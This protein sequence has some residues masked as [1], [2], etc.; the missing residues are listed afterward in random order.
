MGLEP[1]RRL[2]HIEIGIGIGAQAA[3]HG[4]SGARIGLQQWPVPSRQQIARSRG[5]L[6]QQQGAQCDPVKR[7]HAQTGVRELQ[8]QRRLAVGRRDM[9]GGFH[10]GAQ[11]RQH[12][13]ASPRQTLRHPVAERWQRG[14]P[15]GH[16]AKAGQHDRH[17]AAPHI[18]QAPGQCGRHQGVERVGQPPGA[19]GVEHVRG[20]RGMGQH[21]A[22]GLATVQKACLAQAAGGP[23]VGFVV[24]GQ[25][26]VEQGGLF[27]HG[28]GR[29]MACVFDIRSG[30]QCADGVGV[31]QREVGQRS[32]CRWRL[33]PRQ[34]QQPA[35]KH[36]VPA[37]VGMQQ[38]FQRKVLPGA[39]CGMGAHK[40]KVAHAAA[41]QQ[42]CDFGHVGSAVAGEL[43]QDFRVA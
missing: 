11:T 41:A 21:D 28:G 22:E 15:A 30:R 40:G 20:I 32:Q 27:V 5:G 37:P 35:C 9:G 26:Q 19:C 14:R 3:L 16:P 24:S 34:L 12:I 42:A 1:G 10:I 33:V 25:Q 18:D 4:S 38:C 23:A 7:A 17:R 36:L 8:G 2:E 6:V 39:Q 29:E 31:F 43:R 13:V